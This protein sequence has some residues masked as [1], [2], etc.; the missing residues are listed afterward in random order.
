MACPGP[1]RLLTLR[2]LALFVLLNLGFAALGFQRVFHAVVRRATKGRPGPSGREAPGDLV[3][4]TLAAVRRATMLYYRRNK[5]CLHR[6]LVLFYLLK[7]QG[8]AAE[9]KLGV[10]KYPFS[11][12][13]WVQV[14]GVAL[15][16][17]ERDVAR[18]SLLLK[19]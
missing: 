15:M 8:V 12:H 4:G 13:A 9:F 2:A 7:R 17:R 18:L 19:A 6:S 5:D 14:G 10:D 3:R 16:D 1:L 11:A